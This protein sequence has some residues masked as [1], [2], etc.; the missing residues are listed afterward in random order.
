MHDPVYLAAKGR[1]VAG[2]LISPEQASSSKIAQA[3]WYATPLLFIIR[4]PLTIL[5][6]QAAR[7]QGEVKCDTVATF[8][9]LRSLLTSTALPPLIIGKVPIWRSSQESASDAMVSVLCAAKLSLHGWQNKLRVSMYFRFLICS[10]WI[11]ILERL[12]KPGQARL[13]KQ[14]PSH[15]CT[16][17]LLGQPNVK[18]LLR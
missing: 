15:S 5:L 18:G 9:L 1:P 12:R 16:K 11:V 4:W 10:C 8:L 14:N 3:K 17:P 6:V 7:P 2:A 13:A